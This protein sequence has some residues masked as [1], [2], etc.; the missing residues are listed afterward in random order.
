MD[1]TEKTERERAFDEAGGAPR[2][3][4]RPLAEVEAKVK[5]NGHEFDLTFNVY[6]RVHRAY[7]GDSGGPGER[8]L[9]PPEPAH[10]E[11]DAVTISNSHYEVEIDA[12]LPEEVIEALGAA[13]MEEAGE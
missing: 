5:F 13:A 1:D 7:P 3:K 11:V 4:K 10:V 6:G 8:R 12:A 2:S 9:S